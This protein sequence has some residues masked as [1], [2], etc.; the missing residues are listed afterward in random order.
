MSGHS[1]HKLRGTDLVHGDKLSH[2]R[3]AEVTP[4]I[5]VSTNFHTTPLTPEGI[6]E[7]GEK[8][9]R[10]PTYHLYSRRTQPVAVAVEQ[11]LSRINHGYAI[12]YSSGLAACY[13]ALAFYRPKRVAVRDGYLG[14]QMSMEA[15]GKS[16]GLG[17]TLIDLDDE[18]Q[19]GDLCWLETPVNPTGESRDM[20]YYADK[21]HKVGGKLVVDASF[22][23]PPL[24]YPFK[25][26]V[27][28]IMHSA[29]KYL[30]GHSDLL[31]GILVVKIMEEWKELFHNRTYMGSMMGSLEAWLLLRSLRTLHLRVP[32]QSATAS[33][34]ASWLNQIANTPS[35]Q[36]YDGVPGGMISK[37]WHTSLQGVDERGFEPS[38]QMEGGWSATF[39]ILVRLF[40]ESR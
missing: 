40:D 38:K 11:I 29:S 30:G 27:D 6:L 17:L 33:A 18:Y 35:G 10:N 25:W 8:D 28:C 22:G 39:A 12:T 32:R 15:Y 5:A 13:A 14:S 9:P 36:S 16:T 34:L 21:I 26:G 4:S 2:T 7:D 1:E 24:Q 31:S 3:G 19:P 23:P 20:Q 37:V